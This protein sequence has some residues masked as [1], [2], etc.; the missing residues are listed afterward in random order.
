LLLSF[1]V[2]YTAGRV[3]A[4]TAY[5]LIVSASNQRRLEKASE[6]FASLADDSEVL[7]LGSTRGAADDFVRASCRTRPGRAGV[8]RFTVTQ[9]AATL[10]T[11]PMAERSLAPMSGLGTEA[12]AARSIHACREAGE[13]DY[14]RPVADTPGLARALASTLN[15]LR[16]QGIAAERLAAAGAPGQDLSRLLAR[17]ESELVARS[18][19]DL[20]TLFRLAADVAAQS[21]HRLVG[22]RTLLLDVSI[23][24]R[25]K[26]EFVAALVRKSPIV[27]ATAIAADAHT[28]RAL[29]EILGV[30]AEDCDKFSEERSLKNA[31]LKP[32]ATKLEDAGLK[33]AATKRGQ[34]DNAGLKPA[35]TKRDQ[36]GGEA[37]APVQGVFQYSVTEAEKEP[38][39]EDSSLDRV[40]RCIFSPEAPVPKPMD[41]SVEFFSAAGEGLEC[42]EIARRTRALAE[43]G[44]TFDRTAILLRDP[45]LYLPLVEDALRRAGIPGY[46]TRGT[47]RPDP[48]GRAFLALLD[49]AVEGLSASKFAEYLSLGQVPAPDGSGAPPQPRGVWEPPQD[50]AL[51]PTVPSSAGREEERAG[52]PALSPSLR[53]RVDFANGTPGL[54][55]EER[56]GETPALPGETHESAVVGGT[57]RTPFGWEQLLIDASV[58]GGKERWA[59]RLAGLEAEFRLQLKEIEDHT[60][61]EHFERQLER[62]KN[63][64]RFALPLIDRL[65]SWP[66]REHWGEWLSRLKP[67]AEAA[68]RSP[69]SV[70]AVLSDL[71]PME[72]VG[73]VGLSEV[74]QVLTERLRFLRREPPQRRYGQVFVGTIPESS[75]RCFDVVFLPGLAEGIFPRR[76]SEDPLL[77]D[78]D[79]KQIGSGLTTKDDRAFKEG[80]LLRQAAG[81][82]SIKLYASYPRVDIGQG[83]SRVPS[84]YALEILRAAEG[85]LPPLAELERRAAEATES[86][87]GWPAPR[88]PAEAIDDAEHDLALLAPL[89]R[90]PAPE[91][92]GHGR[93]LILANACLA[94]SLRARRDRWNK[95]SWSPADGIVDADERVK[96]VLAGQGM[97]ER[98]YS[99]SALQHFASCPYQFLLYAIHRIQEREEAVAIERLDPLTR[100]ALFHETQFRLFRRLRDA[101]LL[102]MD[103]RNHEQVKKVGDDVLDL[104]AAEYEDKLAPAIPRVWRSEVEELRTDLRGWIRQVAES[105][106]GWTPEHFEFAFGLPIGPERDPES[107]PGEAVILNGVRLRGSIDLIERDPAR[108]VLRVVDHKT[109]KAPAAPPVW[110]GGGELLQ[111]VLYA[112]AAEKLLGKKVESGVLFYST[113]RGNYA[114]HSIAISPDALK[115][116]EL[117]LGAIDAAIQGGFLPANPKPDACEI[118]AYRPVCGPYEESRTARKP[119]DRPEL[120]A[121][122]NLRCQP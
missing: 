65:A 4:V 87:L 104:V 28:I 29:K 79:R 75:G 95:Q 103:E 46:F 17:Y 76:I 23:D 88:N 73:P 90:K 49:C 77:L 45:N 21:T 58:I 19:A 71:E 108:D 66:E 60:R 36:H 106:R 107:I 37:N 84:F 81:A 42:V 8:H 119:Q 10:A 54:S 92:R 39:L 33:P 7:V 3:S 116:I 100:G 102:P 96:K 57:L 56:A 91:V 82:A 35:A 11:E 111:P 122:N 41:K 80:L 34:L 59:R 51:A 26:K 89:L 2:R 120:D 38:W 40:R 68:L 85:R 112:L 20:A 50:E 6:C 93:Y 113:Q 74:R 72:A 14:F 44:T 62:L 55:E 15:E 105:H 109:G 64:E 63:L 97:T 117:A 121:L 16:L 78:D 99:P 118:C 94:R 5:Q 12:L 32:A 52:E 48:A 53:S 61:R 27:V 69:D 31:G 98:P 22:L 13:L 30:E 101:G 43:Q 86:L 1:E 25:S 67:L 24:S 9:L 47:I 83:R 110:I 114:E 18:L 115:R 70:L